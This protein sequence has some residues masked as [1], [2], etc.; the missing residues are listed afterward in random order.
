MK[1]RGFIYRRLNFASN[2]EL[3]VCVIATATLSIARVDSMKYFI[4]VLFLAAIGFLLK[5]F[6]EAHKKKYDT[7]MFVLYCILAVSSAGFGIWGLAH[8][9][10]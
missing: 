8:F 5:M 1:N 6:L 9:L 4:P 7:Y 3:M 10:I 2:I